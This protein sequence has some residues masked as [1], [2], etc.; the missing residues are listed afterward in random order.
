MI[1]YRFILT[2]AFALSSFVVNEPSKE[3]V[4]SIASNVSKK[5]DDITNCYNSLDNSAFQ[6]PKMESFTK[7]LQGYYQLAD[8]GKIRN[9]FLTI[10]ISWCL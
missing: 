2:T 4:K 6:L 3:T 10:I 7:A 8:L 9:Q 5:E 1:F